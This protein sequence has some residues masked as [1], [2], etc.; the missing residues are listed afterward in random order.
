MGAKASGYILNRSSGMMQSYHFHR[1][2]D[3]QI[4]FES[5]F[6]DDAIHHF[7]GGRDLQIH[8]EPRFRD[9]TI[10][11]FHG[12]R[13][14]QIHFEPRFGDDAIHH[15]HGGQ[16]LRIHFEPK[17]R[18]DA[19][20]PHSWGPRPPDTFLDRCPGMIQSLFILENRGLRVTLGQVSRD[21]TIPLQHLYS[22]FRGRSF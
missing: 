10:H 16:D 6:R 12:G 2:R 13:D 7:H 8:F 20:L 5:R 22:P 11:H 3:L 19:I 21:D 1:G 4:H 15:F 9:D 18:D 17:F 14:L